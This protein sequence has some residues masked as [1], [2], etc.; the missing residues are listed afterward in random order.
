MLKLKSGTIVLLFLFSAAANGQLSSPQAVSGEYIV[1]YKNRG[2]VSAGLKIFTKN[3]S[4]VAVKTVFAGAQMMHV[5]VNSESARDSLYSNPD[6]EFVEPNYILSVNPVDLSA[7]G[8]APLPSDSYSQS[9]ANTQ[10]RDSWNIQKPYDQGTKTIV[11]VIDTGLA[12]SHLLFQ[13]SGSIWEN[14][15]EK[16]GVPGVDDDGNGYIDDV[17]GWNFVNNTPNI[18]DDNNHGTHVAGIVLGVGQDVFAT[19]VRESKIRLMTLKFLDGSGNG[20]TASAVNAIYYA[21]SKGAKVINNSWGGPSYSQSLHEAYAHAYN[22]G[23]VIVSAAGNSNTNN[24]VTPMYPANIDSPNNIS[25]I[26]TTSSDVKSSFSNFGATTTHVAAPGSSILSSVPGTGCLAPGCFQMMSG[27]SMAS[28]FVAGLAALV[29]REAPQ[30]SAY[31]VRSIVLASVDT[32]VLLSA[33]G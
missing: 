22:N 26:S 30:L 20:T 19:P 32:F 9:S 18:A 3:Q 10:V 11:A 31:Q 13:D 15:A 28:P 1:K 24:D 4:G 12:T 8:S 2:G 16:N 7:L 25:V 5:K 17:N 21:V 14:S 33:M 27:T 29:V 6:V 23:V